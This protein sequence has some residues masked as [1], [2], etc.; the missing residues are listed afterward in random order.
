MRV[1]GV[2]SSIAVRPVVSD[3]SPRTPVKSIIRGA[4]FEDDPLASLVLSFTASV[5]HNDI[6]N[7]PH[8][9]FVEFVDGGLQLLLVTV[10]AI[11]QV[12]QPPWHVPLSGHRV[13]GRRKPNISDASC[14]QLFR[15]VANDI[16]PAW[17]PPR[18]PV[19]PLGTHSKHLH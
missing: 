2:T 7:A 9:C 6:S 17:A 5:V 1:E 10:F 8:S 14:C 12:V 4:A 18:L 16:I 15:R 3:N 11:V 13:A 19:K